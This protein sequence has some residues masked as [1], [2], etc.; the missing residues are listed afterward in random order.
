MKQIFGLILIV[1]LLTACSGSASPTSQIAPTATPKLPSVEVTQE[2][3]SNLA[4]PGLE[5]GGELVANP[6]PSPTTVPTTG[7]T[8]A[9]GSVETFPDS[10]EY[11]W[12]LVASGLSRPVFL[13]HAGDGTG[14]LFILEQP[15]LIRILQNDL[16]VD[17]PFLDLRDRVGSQANEQGLLGLAFHPDYASN[18][19]FYVNYTDLGGDSVIARFQVDPTDPQQADPNS[20]LILLKI[21]QPYA[22]H[23]GGMLAF[24]PDGLL[25]IGLGDGGSAGDPQN[26]AQSLQSRLGKILRID[27]NDPTGYSAPGSNRFS[28]EQ[29]PEIWAYGLRNPWRFSFDRLTGNLYIGDVGQNQ[30]EEINYLPAGS[31]AGANFG[32]VY[33]EGTHPYQAAPLGLEATGPVFEYGHNQGCSVTG[34]IV[35]RGELLPDW[36][37]I[38]LFADYCSGNISGLLIS[39]Q[40]EWQSKLLFEELGRISSFGEDEPGEIYV[41]EHTGSIFRLSKK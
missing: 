39:L 3:S 2:P 5:P 26:N 34:G 25:Y 40:G 4:S 31:P 16:L 35:Y 33:Y 41:V 23:N 20:E 36:Y 30:W 19:W 18:G 7:E 11:E 9:T 14:W 37:G 1:C 6:S 21:A 13:T 15:G 29:L 24:G 22:N 38:Y 8:E 28:D 27:V 12:Q 32:W 10:T 17:A